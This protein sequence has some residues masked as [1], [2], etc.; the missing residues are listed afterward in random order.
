MPD[1]AKNVM[2]DE[3][4]EPGYWASETSGVLAPVVMR[5]LTGESLNADQLR[6]MKSYLAQWVESPVWDKNPHHRE[7]SRKNLADLR[8][9]VHDIKTLPDLEAAIN[10]AT[11]L[12]MDPL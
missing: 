4:R 7:E 11:E 3:S 6:I 8:T 2:R 12:G 5:Y 9:C 10:A 1:G